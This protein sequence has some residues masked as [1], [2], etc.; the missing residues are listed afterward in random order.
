[1]LIQIDKLK[2]RPR[3]IEIDEPADEFPVL[4]ELNRQGTVL[5]DEP[6][7]GKLTATWAG[8][9]IEV[10]GRLDSAVTLSCGRCLAPVASRVEIDI[11]LCYSSKGEPGGSQ[12]E[13]IEIGSEELGLIFYAGQ[14]IN[15]RPDLE[16]EIIMALPQHVLCKDNCQGLCPVCGGNLNQK[17]CACEK[18]V[19]HAGLEA[20]KDFKI[21]K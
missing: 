9:A 11:L 3:Q 5:F 14:E 21:N 17:S 16:Q 20:L 2:R 12:E 10:S 6:I 13:D 8:D 15:L 18:P 7:Q 1:V 4:R 19:F